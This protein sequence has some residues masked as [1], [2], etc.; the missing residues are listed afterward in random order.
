MTILLGSIALTRLQAVEVDEPRHLVELRAPGAKGSVFQDL[1]RG[2]VRLTLEG[3]F[4]G[5]AALRDMEVLRQAHATAS[6]LS[7]SGDIA[8]GSEITDVVIE[9]FEVRQV[10]GHAFRYEYRLRVSEWTEPPRSTA[11]ELAPVDTGIAADARQRAAQTEQ[12]ARGLT[13]PAALAGALGA[14]PSLLARIDVGELAQAVLGTLGGLDAADFAH[15]LAA[16]TDIDPQKALALLEALGEADSL[17]D[18]FVLFSDEGIG[19][20]E[21]LTGLDLSG[22]SAAVQAFVGGLEFIERARDVTRAAQ[23]LLDALL[24]FNPGV[25]TEQIQALTGGSP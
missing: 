2:S 18:L 16:V 8:V 25:A 10:P 11:D 24:S 6:P 7:F 23:G 15:L 4:L 9:R 5:E 13:D 12:L 22:A 20:V 14:D 1:G 17:Q 19:L 3:I 21:E